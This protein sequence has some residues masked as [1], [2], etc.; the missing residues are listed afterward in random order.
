MKSIF[1]SKTFW[2]NV[3]VLAIAVL[4]YVQG[5][6]TNGVALSVI[7]LAGIIIRTLTTEGVTL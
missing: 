4:Q 5:S 7:G 3:I 1:V 2:L 6:L